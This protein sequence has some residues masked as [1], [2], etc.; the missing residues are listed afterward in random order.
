MCALHSCG[1]ARATSQA[2]VKPEHI[3]MAAVGLAV[4][5]TR[6]ALASR[7]RVAASAKAVAAPV[8]ET[9]TRVPLCISMH[10]LRRPRM[11]QAAAAQGHRAPGGPSR[12]EL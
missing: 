5:L 11:C 10:V 9:G 4:V 12:S 1:A 2:R 7:V 3:E 6:G 8:P